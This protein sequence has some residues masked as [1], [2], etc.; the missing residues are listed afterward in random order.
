MDIVGIKL[1]VYK[2]LHF[3]GIF[4]VFVSLGGIASHLAKG[5]TKEDFPLRKMAAITHG[6]GMFLILLGGFGMLAVL[7]LKALQ[8]W[9]GLKFGFWLIF[10]GATGLLYKMPGKARALWIFFIILGGI[11]AFVATSRPFFF[12]PAG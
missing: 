9:V 3:V 6:I 4:A 12:S 10:G 11:T 2:T 7:G 5:G 8:L 1:L